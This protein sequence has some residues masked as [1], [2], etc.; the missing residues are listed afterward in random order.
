[1]RLYLRYACTSIY[2]SKCF[3]SKLQL[4]GLSLRCVRG[5]EGGGPNGAFH[6][7]NIYFPEL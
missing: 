4:L 7:Y 6:L 5:A 2:G 3:R 1:M